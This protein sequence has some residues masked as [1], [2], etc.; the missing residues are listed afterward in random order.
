MVFTYSHYSHYFSICSP[1]FI[2]SYYVFY[3]YHEVKFVTE[4]SEQKGFPT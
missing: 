3:G 1:Y 2:A 4:M